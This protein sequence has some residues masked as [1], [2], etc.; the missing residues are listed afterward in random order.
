MFSGN[1]SLASNLC[2]ALFVTCALTAIY[3]LESAFGQTVP[4]VAGLLDDGL[5]HPPPATGAFAY[6]SF[7][8]SLTLGTSY[9]EPVFG[10]TVRRVTSDHITD[11]L[12]ARNMYWNADETRY[13]HLTK[14]IEVATGKV[15]HTG[16]PLGNSYEDSGFDPMDPNVLYYYSGS[17]IRKI[18]LNADGTWSDAIYFTAPGGATIKGLG[19]TL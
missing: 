10:T 5:S 6:N 16:I 11:V 1:R 4:P 13:L 19:G 18:T 9:T 7:V 3:P 14:V 12:Y 8:P 2:R 15:T 17:N